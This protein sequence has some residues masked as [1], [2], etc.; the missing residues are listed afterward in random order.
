MKIF[1]I[2]VLI[3]QTIMG[4]AIEPDKTANSDK[5]GDIIGTIIDGNDNKPIEY[6]TIAIFTQ[7]DKLI[8]GG[9][10]DNKGFFRLK[11]NPVG[12]YYLTVTFMGYKTSKISNIKILADTREIDL[13]NILL[14]PNVKELE[15]V[16]VVADQSAV[17]YKIDKKVVNVSQQLTAQSGTA[18][19]V[20]ENVPSVKVDIDGNVSLRGSSSFTVLID[21]RP[22]VLDPSDALA[23]IPAGAIENIE[24]ITNPSAKYEP[25]GAAG[26]INVVTKKNSI[27]GMSG[28]VNANVG[29]FNNYGGD[30]TL[31]TRKNKFH[32][33]FGG[34][35][36]VRSRVGSIEYNR[37]VF[38]P[39]NNN[40][41][42]ISNGDFD[43][44]N[45]RY[46][47]KGGVD[48]DATSVMI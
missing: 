13:G 37:D 40:Y 46:S 26:I 29:R 32:Y 21:G 1:L 38:Y 43:R 47:F 7:E 4:Y 5:R 8:T 20:L 45:E 42:V 11:N 25:N 16:N 36:N 12:D 6:A 17:Q 28:V 19:D 15:G 9:I 23:Q 44:S 33:Y 30:F 24:I 27:Q 18:V 10:S 34:D 3:A 2:G 35:Y 14:D 41:H 39:D 31:D 48:W 22:T